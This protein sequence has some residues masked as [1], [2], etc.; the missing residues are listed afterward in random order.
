MT[1]HFKGFKNAKGKLSTLGELIKNAASVEGQQLPTDIITQAN[2][3]L[4]WL[5]MGFT[6]HLDGGNPLRVAIEYEGPT[7]LTYQ[8]KNVELRSKFTMALST[9]TS[10]TKQISMKLPSIRYENYKL[11]TLWNYRRK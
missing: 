8:I 7:Y 6:R 11:L 9:V 3:Y 4:E 10:I 1:G 2:T 5:I